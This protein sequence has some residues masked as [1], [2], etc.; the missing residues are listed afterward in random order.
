MIAFFDT[1]K[2]RAIAALVV[3]LAASH[4][5]ALLVY[6]RMSADA[7]NLLHDALVA[8]QIATVTKLIET[9]PPAEGARILGLVDAPGLHVTK[10][11][12][13]ALA[14]ELPE[15]TRGHNFEHLLS[16][17]LDRPIGTSIGLAYVPGGVPRGLKTIWKLDDDG[18]RT[19][20]EDLSHVPQRALEEI[21]ANGTVETEILLRNGSWLRFAAPLL[22]VNPFS[23]WKFGASL[24]VGLLSV[25]FAA[26]WV[27]VRWTEPLTTFAHAAERL[28]GDINAPPLSERG[29]AEVR[30][31]AQ[32][33][34]RMQEQ[35]RRLIEDRTQLAAAIAHDLGTPVTR[36]RLRAEEIENQDQRA[37]FLDDLGQM[38]RMISATL[39]FARQDMAVEPIETLDL[40]SLLQSLR[41]EFTDMQ[42]HVDLEGPDHSIAQLRPHAIRRALTNVIDN[43]VKYG[44]RACVRLSESPAG[45]T[46]I[47]EDEGP[48][49]PESLRGEVFKPFHRLEQAGESVTQGTGLGL[50]VAQT[51]V[52]DHG[53]DIE[54]MDRPE[55]G[56]RV[57]MTL[58]RNR[59]NKVT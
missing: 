12:E 34:N 38:Q 8:E 40:S 59:I 17:I 52:R 53:G 13:R 44:K 11:R 2:G 42:Q 54:L 30:A 43:A 19:S 1:M 47:I 20:H 57:V 25:M 45:H 35:L 3:L 36:L 31:A 5:L 46:I 49:I 21:A 29:P 24:L 10:A 48:G 7:N 27:M 6:A 32:A 28:G 16:A 26:M 55:G 51:I 41:D 9:L 4:L 56:L 37:K 22:S 58:P 15:G 39:D 18:A 50:T 33:F 23:T 14:G